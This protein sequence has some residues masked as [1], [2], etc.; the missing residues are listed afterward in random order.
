[1]VAVSSASFLTRHQCS[2]AGFLFW[3][4]LSS[5]KNE[6]YIL[7]QYLILKISLTRKK[8]DFIELFS[9]LERLMTMD[10]HG[11]DNQALNG[12]KLC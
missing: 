9:P 6:K 10:Q 4:Q 1:M 5:T 11:S 8:F 2:V 3:F 12:E 7:F